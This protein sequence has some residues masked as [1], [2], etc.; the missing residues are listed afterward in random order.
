MPLSLYRAYLFKFHI[1]KVGAVEMA[2]AKLLRHALR[3]TALNTCPAPYAACLRLQELLFQQR[4]SGLI[5]DTLLQL[6]V[7]HGP[8]YDCL[9]SQQLG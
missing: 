1:Q 2:V 3:I 4:K 5:L 8:G 9:W 7:R 6:E